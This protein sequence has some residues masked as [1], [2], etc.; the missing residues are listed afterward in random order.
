MSA[1][2]L[3][4][5]KAQPKLDQKEFLANYVKGEFKKALYIAE[6]DP[7]A[8]D[9]SIFDLGLNSLGAEVLKQRFENELECKIDTTDFFAN[10]TVGYFIDNLSV[11]LLDGEQVANTVVEG[12]DMHDMVNVM[13]NTMYGTGGSASQG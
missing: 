6:S 5:L 2:I 1:D 8:N 11:R 10:P 9:I 13:L 4:Q 3:A 12:D 7:I